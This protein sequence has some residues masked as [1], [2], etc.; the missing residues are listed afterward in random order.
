MKS[1]KRLTKAQKMLL[2]SYNLNYE[3]WLVIKNL[4]HELHLVHRHTNNTRVLP[5]DDIDVKSTINAG[6]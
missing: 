6:N 2:T 5:K 3:N 1:G 4:D